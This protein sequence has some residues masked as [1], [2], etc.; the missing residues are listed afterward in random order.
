MNRSLRLLVFMACWLLL[1]ALRVAAG[2]GDLPSALP[3]NAFCPVTTEERVE[4]DKFVDYEGRRIWFCCNKCKRSFQSNPTKYLANLPPS[5]AGEGEISRSAAPALAVA[6][7]ADLLSPTTTAPASALEA[8]HAVEQP[9]LTWLGAW[10][11]VIVH[12]PIACLLLA[13]LGEVLSMLCKCDS[14]RPWVRWNLYTGAGFA[15]VTAGLG[16]LAEEFGDVPREMHAL[17]ERHETL[18]LISAGLGLVTAVLCAL[19]VKHPRLLT[20]YRVGLILSAIFVGLAGHYG[21]VL[22]HGADHF[23]WPGGPTP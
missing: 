18:G 5:P 14:W 19:S 2:P 3:G 6:D 13:A 9:L 7:A 17:V 10:H 21:G 11:V 4:A 20:A 16:L 23:D 15:L 12:F 1:V 22:V 8:G